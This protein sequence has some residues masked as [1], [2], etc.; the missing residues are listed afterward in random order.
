MRANKR[1]VQEVTQ[2]FT[3]ELLDAFPQVHVEIV[4][5][6]SRAADASLEVTVPN[7]R[8]L[9]KVIH[10]L[11]EMNVHYFIETGVYI[12]ASTYL[13]TEGGTPMPRR[14]TKTPASAR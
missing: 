4:P 9:F 7:V 10:K 5:S 12:S 13:P 3:R 8:A 2:A 14:R 1:K 11:A 6:R